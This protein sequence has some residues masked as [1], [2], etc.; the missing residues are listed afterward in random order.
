M[1]IKMIIFNEE[2]KIRHEISDIVKE[3]ILNS[4]YAVPQ[5][6]LEIKE[7][8]SAVL[9]FMKVD[10]HIDG[11]GISILWLINGEG[12]FFINEEEYHLKKGDVLVFDDNIPHS[13]A[14]KEICTAVNFTL[15][16]VE[17]NFD[18]IKNIVQNFNEY[19]QQL[20]HCQVVENN[21]KIRNK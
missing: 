17:F 18:T 10:E 5:D 4:G 9:H 13:F 15:D 3:E 7:N 1:G 14:S 2:P 20:M 21:K 6:D 19:N 11:N 12:S 16:V 8:N